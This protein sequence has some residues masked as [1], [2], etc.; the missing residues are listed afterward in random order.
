MLKIYDKNQI[1]ET[2][3]IMIVDHDK[4]VHAENVQNGS[5]NDVV[6]SL[7]KNYSEDGIEIK[8]YEN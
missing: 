8:I 6:E 7:K 1:N 2:S 5:K 4:P 3:R